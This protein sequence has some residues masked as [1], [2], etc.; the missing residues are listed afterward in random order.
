[1]CSFLPRSNANTHR[2]CF[3]PIFPFPW[4]LPMLFS[5]RSMCHMTSVSDAAKFGHRR[6][7][8]GICS[9]ARA[10][11][12]R[13]CIPTTLKFFLPPHPCL[14]QQIQ[15]ASAESVGSAAR[16]EESVVCSLLASKRV[17]NNI[18]CSVS[19]YAFMHPRTT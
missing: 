1:M 12:R 16:S 18:Y 9:H 17:G 5:H 4:S 15:D 14:Q 3:L 6:G 7:K 2:R 11:D 8:P 19:E 10:I 13:W